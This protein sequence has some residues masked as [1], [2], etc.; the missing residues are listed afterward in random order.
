MK[1]ITILIST[2]LFFITTANASLICRVGDKGKI[3]NIGL[4]DNEY[5]FI[6]VI[7]NGSGVMSSSNLDSLKGKGVL[8]LIN[9]AYITKSN[10]IIESCDSEYE[11]LSFKIY[12]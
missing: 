5:Q 8:D 4:R 10:I 9:S 6:I 2:L 1:N 7:D 12:K 11:F 3:T